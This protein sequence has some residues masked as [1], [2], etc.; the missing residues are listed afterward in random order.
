MPALQR[1]EVGLQRLGARASTSRAA[2]PRA[3]RAGMPASAPARPSAT[4]LVQLPAMRLRHLLERQRRRSARR[5]AVNTSGG[6]PSSGSP[7]ITLAARERDLVGEAVARSASR[8][9]AAGRSGRRARRSAPARAAPAPPPRRRGSAARWCAPS[10][11]RG[12]AFAG[13]VEQQR[14]RGHHAA[15]AAAGER[16]RDARGVR[17]RRARRAPRRRF[18]SSMAC[19][20]FLLRGRCAEVYR[21]R[22]RSRFDADQGTRNR[23]CCIMICTNR[24][25]GTVIPE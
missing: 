12:P 1:G 24:Y 13:G 2:R 11:R 16:D 21:L 8:S 6:S 19:T 22:G 15:A 3:R 4:M 7:T 25:C 20:S 14:A 9:R 10:G 23:R 5:V 17:A 18:A